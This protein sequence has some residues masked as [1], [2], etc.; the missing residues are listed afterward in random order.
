MWDVKTLALLR[1]IGG[2]NAME[3]WCCC[4]AFS[5]GGGKLLATVGADLKHRLQLW[6]RSDGSVAAEAGAF[7]DV[8]GGVQAIEWTSAT[9]L[10]TCGVKGHLCIWTCVGR[11]RCC[12]HSP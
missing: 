12:S 8:P 7:N 1:R 6:K 2:E 3:R 5:P 4:M 9:T 11:G 10:V